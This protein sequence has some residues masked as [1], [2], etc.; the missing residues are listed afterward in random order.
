MAAIPYA[1]GIFSLSRLTLIEGRVLHKNSCR[2]ASGVE[3]STVINF[4]ES[5]NLPVQIRYDIRGSHF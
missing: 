2:D 3:K 4:M 5:H 1:R